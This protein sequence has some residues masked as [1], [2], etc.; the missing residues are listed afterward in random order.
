MYARASGLGAVGDSY[1]QLRET[2]GRE[3]PARA[4][5]RD[6]W[7]AFL[8]LGPRIVDLQHRAALEA[9]RCR[10]RGD[11]ECH[12]EAQQVIRDLGALNVRHGEVV[13]RFHLERMGEALGLA[14]YYGGL[15]AWFVPA[16]AFSSVALV[17][18]WAFRAYELNER[19]LELIE[20]GVLT[21]AEAAA[22]DPGPA[23]GSFLG[24]LE[25]LGKLVLAGVVVWL[26]VQAFGMYQAGRS[27]RPNP[28]EVWRVN[29]PGTMSRRVYDV[30]YRHLEDGE[31]YVHDFGPDVELEALDDGTVLLSHSEGLPLWADFEVAE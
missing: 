9:G 27:A 31:D 3:G 11:M 28:L 4:Y 2:L 8:N 26:A 16:A 23:P 12:A 24:D 5:L 14:G 30:R 10:E 19:K 20:R 6:R 25:G 17:A 21:P 1:E 13:D 7:A 29:P 22:L 15:G 18:L